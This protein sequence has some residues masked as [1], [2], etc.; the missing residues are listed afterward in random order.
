M[1][2]CAS[3]SSILRVTH[4]SNIY[5]QTGEIDVLEGVHDNEHNQVSWH[6][7]AGCN[8]TPKPSNYTG[9]TIV[10][11]DCD[12]TNGKSGCGIIEYS[13]ASYGPYF[14]SQ[15]GGVFAMKWDADSIAV[16]NFYRNAV[17]AD[18]VAGVP[19]PLAWG[20]PSAMLSP[21]GCDLIKNFVN[22]SMIFG[23][24]SRL[25]TIGLS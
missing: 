20:L 2:I 10:S 1:A 8:I 17:P 18:I 21:M 6:T 3:L 13:R 24:H 9:T 19:N 23:D 15:G 25:F 16:W 5:I 4:R 7:N 22:H 11:E 12:S 14:D